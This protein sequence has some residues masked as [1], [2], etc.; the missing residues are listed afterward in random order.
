ML[1]QQKLNVIEDCGG[2]QEIAAK[3]ALTS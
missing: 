2:D 1:I 3:A